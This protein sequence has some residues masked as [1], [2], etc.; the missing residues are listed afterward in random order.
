[1]KNI[2]KKLIKILLFSLPVFSPYLL[3]DLLLINVFIRTSIESR[4]RANA[5]E[6]VRQGIVKPIQIKG[7]QVDIKSLKEQGFSDV[8][9][10]N[11]IHY[12]NKIPCLDCFFYVS[13][14]KMLNYYVNGYNAVIAS[15]RQHQE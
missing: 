12:S 9:V 1:M 3:I 8:T 13:S 7:G 15:H 14:T 2:I 10:E 4:A 6:D 11:I 5:Q